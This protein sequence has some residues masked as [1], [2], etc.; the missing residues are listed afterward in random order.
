VSAPNIACSAAEIEML[1]ACLLGATDTAAPASANV[2]GDGSITSIRPEECEHCG[3]AVAPA[4]G[5]VAACPERCW[6]CLPCAEE[7]R[8]VFGLVEDKQ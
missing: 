6:V 3:D 4:D 2:A 8:V 7:V 1:T 5:T